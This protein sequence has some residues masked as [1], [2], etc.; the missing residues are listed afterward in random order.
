MTTNGDAEIKA[1][2]DRLGVAKRAQLRAHINRKNTE[3]VCSRARGN[4]DTAKRQ[5]KEANKDLRDAR[6]ALNNVYLEYEVIEIDDD[7]DED[8]DSESDED[9]DTD[10]NDA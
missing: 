7:E 4:Y 6:T 3:K 1:V 10:D 5:L 8:K 2:E 9:T